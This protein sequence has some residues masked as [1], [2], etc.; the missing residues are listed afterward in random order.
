[1]PDRAP[2]VAFMALGITQIAHLGNAR[3]DA[4]VVRRARALAN[5]YA[6]AGVAISLALQLATSLGPLASILGVRSL[7][8][9]QWLVVLMCAAVPATGGQ[10]L[11]LARG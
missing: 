4:D 10:V 2:P 3:S 5:G 6:L 11:E 7:T 1:M 8:T 9:G